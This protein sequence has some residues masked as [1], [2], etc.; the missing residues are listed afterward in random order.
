[1]LALAAAAVDDITVSYTAHTRDHAG[2]D[3][4][5]FCNNRPHARILFI[6]LAARPEWKAQSIDLM[7]DRL[8][9]SLS[10]CSVGNVLKVTRQG[11][12]RCGAFLRGSIYLFRVAHN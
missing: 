6:T 8:T 7:S 10:V 5:T 3:H 2:T 9:V 11:Q 4:A 1:M 12:H